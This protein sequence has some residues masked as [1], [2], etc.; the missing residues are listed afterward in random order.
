MRFSLFFQCRVNKL[1]YVQVYEVII[2]TDKNAL[3]V[4][5]D[6][7]DLDGY[8]SDNGFLMITATK[9]IFFYSRVQV[10]EEVVRSKLSVTHVGDKKYLP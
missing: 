3:F 1:P 2:S 4:W 5:V 10:S 9:K 7:H 8:F 6:A